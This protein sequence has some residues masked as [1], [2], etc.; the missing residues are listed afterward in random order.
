MKLIA[1]ILVLGLCACA[2]PLDCS[3]LQ[4]LGVGSATLPDAVALLGQP[5][6]TAAGPGGTTQAQW[7]GTRHINTGGGAST[8]VQLTFGPDG[9][10]QAKDCATKITAPLIK[11]PAA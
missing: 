10:L 3:A 1:L 7:L 5:T 8:R 4:R 9:K 6:S 2:K 11:E